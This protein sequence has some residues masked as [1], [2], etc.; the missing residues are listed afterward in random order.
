MAGIQAE[1]Y[2]ISCILQGEKLPIMVTIA[3]NK[4]VSALQKEIK[5]E[6]TGALAGVDANELELYSIDFPDDRYLEENVD[7]LLKGGSLPEVLR[8]S[9]LLVQVFSENPPKMGSVHILIKLPDVGQM[10]RISSGESRMSV[11]Y[12]DTPSSSR[13]RKRASQDSG[14]EESPDNKKQKMKPRP[15]DPTDGL[16]RRP[17]TVRTLYEKLEEHRF[18]FVRGTPASGKSSLAIL[19]RKYIV[20]NHPEK[21]VYLL[22]RYRDKPET[23]PIKQWGVWLKEQGCYPPKDG[24]LILDEA[25]L[26]YWDQNFWLGFLKPINAA[27]SYMVILFA[28]YG[29]ASRSLLSNST[30]FLVLKE[31]LVGLDPGN[32]E[33]SVGLL[34]TRK[35]MD[36]VIEKSFLHHYFDVS[37]LNYVHSLTSGHVG[38]CYDFLMVVKKDSS[39]RSMNSENRK[40]TY[41]DFVLSFDMSTFLEKLSNQGVFSR[42]LP[43]R[44]DLENPKKKF[45]NSLRDVLEAPMRRVPL[46]KEQD[47][48]GSGNELR[49]CL[50]QGWLFSEPAGDTTV[51]YRFASQLHELYTEWLLL[52]KES[53]IKD[54]DLQTFVIKVI[55]R[56]SPRNLKERDDLSSTPQSIPEAQFQQEFYRACCVYTGGCVTTFPEFGHKN[57]RIDF[58]IRS[59]KWG[60]ELLREGM[61]LRDHTTRFTHGEYK[62]WIDEGYMQ[63][64]IMIDFRSEKPEVLSDFKLIYV[65]SSDNWKSVEI[66]D[67]KHQMIKSYN[68]LYH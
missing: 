60:V 65:V 25:Q 16:Y 45:T 7:H 9:N 14:H 2:D 30:P 52:S 54:P 23:T 8:P 36:G 43:R 57:G 15:S 58:F 10:T 50:E 11:E 18:I 37:L 59:K 4:R 55:K 19:L 46:E 39:Y 22:E 27:T 12:S 17:M 31:Q 1:I 41:D 42:G 20:E 29:S 53:P 48:S 5:K 34:L 56:F 6:K 44:S 24:V 26:S 66:Y 21:E 47:Q 32:T 49:L 67:R 35:E 62:K 51:E 38:A 33:P 40:Y 63:D 28:S 61:R 64:Y 13:I 3:K 68:L